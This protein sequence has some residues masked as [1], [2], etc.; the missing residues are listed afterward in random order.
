MQPFVT[1]EDLAQ[2]FK[3]SVS[4]LRA[5]L[6][7]GH[8]PTDTYFKIGSTYRFCLE[9]V[10]NAMKRE[11]QGEGKDHSIFTELNVDEDV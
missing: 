6:R 9:D 5:W 7:N 2:H 11:D 10:C 1:V 4:T 3:V 8:I